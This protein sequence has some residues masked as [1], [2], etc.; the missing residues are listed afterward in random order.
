MIF[1]CLRLVF[2]VVVGWVGGG[3]AGCARRAVRLI[4]A[5]LVPQDHGSSWG[6][7]CLGSSVASPARG[8][9]LIGGSRFPARCRA[10]TDPADGIRAMSGCGH[11]IRV[12][13][14]ANPAS[15]RAAATAMIV[16]RLARFS[17]RLQVRYSRCWAD[18]AI[19]IASPG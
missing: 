18:H 8:G 16:R 3:P 4:Y 17:S 9:L 11:S 10:A 5:G 15:S 12:I 19:A 7:R 14:Q 1:T 2:V 13:A 6:G